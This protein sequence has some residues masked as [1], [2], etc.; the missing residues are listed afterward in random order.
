MTE[1]DVFDDKDDGL[2]FDKDDGLNF[3][4]DDEFIL[5]DWEVE[6]GEDDFLLAED[7]LTGDES[8]SRTAPVTFGSPQPAR[9]ADPQRIRT[10]KTDEDIATSESVEFEEEE[11]LL[12][13][14]SLESEEVIAPEKTA[15]SE[16]PDEEWGGREIEIEDLG[17]ELVDRPEPVLGIDDEDDAFEITAEDELT[18]VDVDGELAEQ[19]GYTSGSPGS[20]E[21]FGYDDTEQA[22]PEAVD[23]NTRDFEMSDEDD[24]EWA[25]VEGSFVDDEDEADSEEVY[26]ESEV[27]YE[28]DYEAP[29]YSDYEEAYYDETEGQQSQRPRKS[30]VLPWVAGIAAALLVSAFGGIYLV[31]PEWLI[32]SAEQTVIDVVQVDRPQL[33][34]ALEPP[35]VVLPSEAV[36]PVVVDPV[37]VDPVVVDPVEVDP[38]VVDPVEVDPVEVDPVVVDPVEVDPVLVDPMVENRFEDPGT[39]RL[40]PEG[41]YIAGDQR[42]QLTEEQEDVVE[43]DNG[44]VRGSRALAQLG[45]ENIF[46]G[47]VKAMDSSFVT[48]RMDVGEITLDRSELSALLPLMSSEYEEWKN[49]AAGYIRLRNNNRLVGKV[50]EARN[51]SIVLMVNANRVIIPRSAI[52]EVSESVGDTIQMDDSESLENDAWFREL[53]EKKV[54]EQDEVRTTVKV[55]DTEV[56]DK[57]G[58]AK[59]KPI[60]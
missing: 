12:T 39:F 18:L 41:S 52:E 14:A 45:N 13:S 23:Y 38:V 5:A 17:I 36:D 43:P 4:E 21:S 42:D 16:S 32:R 50:V 44:L 9:E 30:R 25:P 3:D 60:K 59:A 11:I 15:F 55:G 51:D 10:P 49:V 47:W 19:A 29:D 48:L 24:P 34:I 20:T 33:D 6:E 27:S 54:T 53:V 31:K 37:E 58:K 7:P 40:D 28:D 56:V 1:D 46:V 26:E 35:T 2:N 22:E 8:P 57:D